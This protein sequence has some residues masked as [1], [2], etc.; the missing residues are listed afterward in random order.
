MG[1]PTLKVLLLICFNI[2]SVAFI[3]FTRWPLFTVTVIIF[4][5]VIV[6]FFSSS[7]SVFSLSLSGVLLSSFVVSFSVFSLSLSFFSSFS[8]LALGFFGTPLFL[9]VLVRFLGLREFG[10]LFNFFSFALSHARHSF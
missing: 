9:N 8:M 4:S 1:I 2:W 10:C 5:C 3:A 6:N 7:V